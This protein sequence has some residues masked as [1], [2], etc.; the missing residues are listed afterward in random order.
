MERIEGGD[1]QHFVVKIQM[2]LNAR[3]PTELALQTVGNNRITGHI[4]CAPIIGVGWVS[5]RCAAAGPF[6]TCN[7][8]VRPSAPRA[9]NASA[10]PLVA[11]P[12]SPQVE[13]RGEKHARRMQQVVLYRSK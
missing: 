10:S 8:W 7:F 9:S 13:D 2:V 5:E 11:N 4:V 6:S 3:G 12:C 1:C